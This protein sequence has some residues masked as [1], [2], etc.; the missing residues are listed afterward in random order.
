MAD[1]RKAPDALKNWYENLPI[2]PGG[3]PA[4]GTI[5][6]ALVVLE[7][8]KVEFDLRLESHRAKAGQSQIKGVSGTAVARILARFGERRPFLRE[9]GRTNRGAPGD[10]G[11]MLRS[12]QEA[13]LEGLSPPERTATIERLQE[14]LV[15]K[16]REFHGRQRLKVL[17]DPAKTTQQLVH[18]MLRFAS[19]SGKAGPVAQHLVGA[20]LQLRFPS[21]TVENRPFS[22]ADEQVGHPG[23]FIVGSTAFHVT[24]APMPG[25]FERCREN[26]DRGLRVFLLVPE[27]K[28]IGARQN[29]D[30]VAP[31]RIAVE[32]IESF[33]SQNIEELSAFSGEQ[34]ADQFRQLLETYNR[35]V[36]EAQDDKSL[37][38]EIPPNLRKEG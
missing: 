20:K 6:A 11:R 1:K 32:S 12:L 17:F 21:L 33:V 5:G 7:R 29:A 14:F 27:E 8:L 15:T 26:I 10:I 34:L 28:L 4:R 31:G 13:G 37:M 38:V 19:E 23:D 30:A 36:D 22:A 25:V 2:Q 16:V 3:F 18:D 24:V 35:R 9:G